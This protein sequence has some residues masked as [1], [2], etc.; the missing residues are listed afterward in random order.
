[1]ENELGGNRLGIQIIGAGMYV[2]ETIVSNE[3]FAKIVDTSDEWI[4]TRT[5]IKT[6]HIADG[7][8]AYQMGAKAALR[9]LEDANMAVEQV[10]M[11]LVTTVTADCLTPSLACMIAN[12][13]GI[14]DAICMDINAA[15][16]G[17]VFALDIAKKY[18]DSGDLQTVLIV[19]AEMLTRMIDYTDRSTC[20]LFGDGA[21][22]TIV[23]K[24]NSLYA[25]CIKSSPKGA[26]KI[27]T[28]LPEPKHPFQTKTYRWNDEDV[29]KA[30]IG[31][32]QMAGNDV[33]KFATTAMPQA[34]ELAAQ[35]ANIS[36]DEIDLIIPHQANVR[37]IN[38]A[39]K[40]LKL[41][42]EKFYINIEEF[43]NI[44]SACIPLGLAQLKAAGRLKQGD[45][46]CLVGFGAGLTY[47]AVIFEY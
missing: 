26:M 40:K 1:M 13:I 24:S 41:P 21:A 35:K 19:S 9:A 39:I 34:V 47:G 7:E 43:G 3:D 6:R 44:S 10:D 5:G 38:T 30:P 12:E 8:L 4:T 42:P 28:K 14:E 29:A 23:K 27:Y 16:A 46:I 37:I 20:V 18:L 15:C 31:M 32:I 11:V 2:P 17:Y 22:A 36:L 25:S 33:Y 45:K